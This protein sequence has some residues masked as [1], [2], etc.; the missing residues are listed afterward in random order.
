M[1]FIER[2]GDLE[3]VIQAKKF[4]TFNARIKGRKV[5]VCIHFQWNKYFDSFDPAKK[6]S[7]KAEI[8]ES[9][10][11]SLKK[12][13]FKEK[14]SLPLNIDELDLEQDKK[15]K[16]FDVSTFLVVTYKAED[17]ELA[18]YGRLTKESK[19]YGKILPKGKNKY[20]KFLLGKGKAFKIHKI[21]TFYNHIYI[22]DEEENRYILKFEDGFNYKIKTKEPDKESSRYNIIKS[23]KS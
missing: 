12:E 13:G 16:I 3:K 11:E 19:I 20:P 4:S 21:S 15:V 7:S 2:Y 22:Y 23:I 18:S 8:I 9:I 17:D 14:E 5:K 1:T 10:K 6:F